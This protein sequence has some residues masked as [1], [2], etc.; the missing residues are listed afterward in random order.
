M[1]RPLFYCLAGLLGACLLAAGCV[2]PITEEE[3]ETRLELAAEPFEALGRRRLIP[4]YAETSF[5]A[6]ALL[7]EARVNPE[8]PLTTQVSKRL[9]IAARRKFHVVLGGPYPDLSDRIL[10]NAFALNRKQGLAGLTI[11][12]VSDARPSFELAEAASEVHAHL[13]HRPLP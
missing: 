11:V 13:H 8:S 5:I 9:G 12:Y 2:T 4:I 6:R 1:P 7:T 10:L 3:L